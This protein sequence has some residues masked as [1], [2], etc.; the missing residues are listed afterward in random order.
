MD[1]R[2]ILPFEMLW[3]RPYQCATVQLDFQLPATVSTSISNVKIEPK[4][5]SH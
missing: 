3:Q 4:L 1:L 2:L 5:S